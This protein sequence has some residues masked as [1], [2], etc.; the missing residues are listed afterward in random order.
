MAQTVFE[1]VGGFMVVR[2]IVSA[3]YERVLDSPLV[4]HHFAGVP[5]ARLIDHQTQFI[6]QLLGGPVRISDETLQHA[7]ARLRITKE[8]FEEIVRL[9]GNTLEEGGLGREDVA[10]VT[11]EV[12]RREPLIVTVR[13]PLDV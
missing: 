1:R 3:F 11:H 4:Q 6:S 5:M 9:L 12:R 13:A 7:H 10:F 8:E 2:K